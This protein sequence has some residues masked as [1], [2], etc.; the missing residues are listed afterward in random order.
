MLDRLV[1]A[2]RRAANNPY[3]SRYSYLV[4]ATVPTALML[5]IIK[6]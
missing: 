6:T 1:A 2:A 5:A 3:E 4:S